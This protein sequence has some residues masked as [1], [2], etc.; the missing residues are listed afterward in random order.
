MHMTEGQESERIVISSEE[1]RSDDIDD[2][3]SEM[4]Q[5]RKVALV[6][7]VGDPNA[8]SGGSL[9]AVLTL[10]VGGA[11]GGILA[12]LVNR[13]LLS[14]LDLFPDNSFLNNLTFTFIL[15]F[16]IGL[17][18]ALASVITDRSWAKVGMVAAIAAPA[19][20]GAAL[21][22]GLIAHWVYSTGTDWLYNEAFDQF[23]TGDLTEE[24]VQ[25][26]ILLRLH[27]IRGAAW[28]LVGIS[29]GIAAGA[30]SRSWKRVGLAVLG[31]AIGGFLGGFIFDF[32]PAGD[33]DGATG[34]MIAQFIGIVL[35]GT[36]IGLA[37]ALIEQAGK[38]RWIEIVAGGLAGKQFI[39]YKNVITMGSAPNA[40]ITLIKDPAIPPIAARITVRGQVATLEA[41]DPLVPVLVN[42]TPE[43]RK[44]IVDSD[45]IAI[46]RT[47]IRFREKNSKDGVPGALRH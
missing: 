14:T 43:P 25:S 47:Q 9:R 3:I 40:D 16:F 29:A 19:A 38:S 6:R 1:L 24:Q 46:G 36:L 10:T 13:L 44:Q 28:L 39:L 30:A 34:E 20:I 35:L 5:A 45:V 41:A 22:M 33:G 17:S 18:V 12:F 23:L 37:M 2:R 21:L 7:E 42:G 8:K 15:A 26:Y 31:G 4:E 11:V 32:I 27:P